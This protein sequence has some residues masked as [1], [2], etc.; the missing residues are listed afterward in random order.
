MLTWGA[1][2]SPWWYRTIPDSRTAA[3]VRTGLR[4][5]G[6]HPRCARRLLGHR[7]AEAVADHEHRPFALEVVH[8]GEGARKSG[9]RRSKT[10]T[11]SGR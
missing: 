5:N 7:A 3:G 4:I 1:L 2:R 10:Q 9:A 6:N 11:I 8:A